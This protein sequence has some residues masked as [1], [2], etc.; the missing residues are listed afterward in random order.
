M[1][2]IAASS[3]LAAISPI[4]ALSRVRSQDLKTLPASSCSISGKT[5]QVTLPSKSV[6]MLVLTPQ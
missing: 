4:A 3:D 6:A 2:G 1:T 5:L